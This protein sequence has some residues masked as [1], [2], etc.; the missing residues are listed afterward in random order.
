MNTQNRSK[1]S[2]KMISVAL[3]GIFLWNQI[4]WAAD[5]LDPTANPIND[6]SGLM[7]PNDLTAN[8]ASV[9]SL[10]N[11]RNAIEDFTPS[12]NPVSPH[13]V[14]YDTVKTSSGGNVYY[15]LEGQLKERIYSDGRY[16]IYTRRP[17]GKVEKMAYYKADSSVI[18]TYE[19]SYN[20]NGE[21]TGRI[22]K[23]PDG[24]E[25]HYD[26]DDKLVKK[27]DSNGSYR[28]YTR[29]SDG[30]VETMT[31]C[32]SDGGL[33]YKNITTYDQNGVRTGWSQIN[34]DG[35]ETH[36]DANNE[37]IKKVYA[38]GRY[39][40]YTRQPDGQRKSLTSYYANNK[41][42]YYVQHF[43]DANG[44]RTGCFQEYDGG[45]QFLRD[46]RG[47]IIRIVYSDGRT[48]VYT[49]RSDGKV[50]ILTCYNTEGEIVDIKVYNYDSDDEWLLEA[51]LNGDGKAY[52]YDRTGK[53]IR[54]VGPDASYTENFYDSDG[55]LTGYHEYYAAGAIKVF[56]KDSN[57][58]YWYEASAGQ[59][60][61]ADPASVISVTTSSG[62][63]VRYLDGGIFSVT[64][65]EDG[66]TISRI[67][68]DPEGKLRNAL[69]EYS[70]GSIGVVYNGNLL[71]T[72][73]AGG[74]LARYR[75]GYKVTEYSSVM[76]LTVFYYNKDENG[77]IN[78]VKTIN[79]EAICTY[80]PN[81]I[82]VKFAKPNGEVAE[83]ENGR[84][85]RLATPEGPVYTYAFISE[86]A[87]RSELI[88]SSD[89]DHIPMVI[90]YDE[91]GLVSE[92]RNVK[93]EVLTCES[94][95]PAGLM[96]DGGNVS[97]NYSSND[98]GYIN[99]V[100]VKRGNLQRIYD[101][102]GDLVRI[103]TREDMIVDF[104]KN[105]D[106][107]SIVDTGGVR[108]LYEDKRLSAITDKEG[109][110]YTLDGLN[111]VTRAKHPDGRE[112]DYAYETGA[113]GEVIVVVHDLQS[114]S[115]RYYREDLLYYQVN[116]IGLESYYEYSDGKLAH[117]TQ[118]KGEKV[119]NEFI[120]TYSDTG[121]AIRDLDGAVRVFDPNGM[122]REF[123]DT[124]G[125]VHR[126]YHDDEGNMISEFVELHKDNGTI[127][128][129]ADG[130]VDHV[131]CPNGIV[132]TNIEFDSIGK[133][134]KF[135]LVLTDGATRTCFVDGEWTEIITD[136]NTKLI[137]R[138]YRLVAVNTKGRV[139]RFQPDEW[140]S[141]ITTGE[142]EIEKI[143]FDT[144]CNSNTWKVQTHIS[145]RGFSGAAFDPANDQL[146]IDAG[147]I[148]S[149]Y[150]YRQGEIYLDLQ[151][152]AGNVSGPL[153]LRDQEISFLVKLPEGAFSDGKPLI[154]QVFAK[155]NRWLS[156]YGTEV[157]LTQDGIWYRVSLIPSGK[158]CPWGV[159]D[160][161][162]NADNI[163]LI[164]LRIK[165]PYSNKSYNGKIYMK[166]GNDF[167]LP[168]GETY[169]ETPML[170]SK[171]SVEPYIG[172]IPDVQ[173]DPGNPNYIS[174]EAMRT[175]VDPGDG[176]D[177]G[178]LDLE[179][180]DWRAQDIDY[181]SGIRA[182]T[183]DDAN[184]Q[185]VLETKLK[186]AD[187]NYHH[188]EM[189][190]D[191]RY[192]VPGYN[193]PGPLDLTGKELKFKVKIPSG[194]VTSTGEPC[195]AQ[196]FVK[197]EEYDFQYGTS[198]FLEKEDTW[199]TVTL[200]PKNGYIYNGVTAGNFEPARIINIGVKISCG[201]GSSIDHE[202]P[203]FV[204]CETP[205]EVF[206]ENSP[207]LQI[208]V[209]GLKQY[210]VQ[211]DMI[212]SFEEQLGPEI[213]LA[214]EHLPDYFKDDS[215][216]MRTVYDPRGKIICALKGNSRVEH[217][218]AL[219]RLVEITDPEWDSVVKY[220]YDD[221]GD[222]VD[223]N[224]EGT[225]IKTSENIRNARIEIET[226]TAQAL[227]D[228]GEAK[229]GAI[230]H[231]EDTI[232]SQIGSCD[233]ALGQLYSQLNAVNSWKPLWPWDR[234]KKN[235]VRNDIERQI[236]HVGDTR[237]KLVW[238]KAEAYEQI[239][240]DIAEAKQGIMDE[241]NSSMAIV[242]EREANAEVE[243][244]QQ[245][246]E[247]ILCVYYTKILGRN[248]GRNE[249]DSWL[250]VAGT[251]GCLDPRNRIAFD[252][253]VLRKELLS[254]SEYQGKTAFNNAVRKRVKDFLYNYL[255]P[256]TTGSERESLL[257]SLGLTSGE[258]NGL[259][260]AAWGIKDVDLIIDWMSG[261]DINFGYCAFDTVRNYLK[262]KGIEQ[263]LELVAVSLI[264]IDILAGAI[265]CFTE[266]ALEISLYAMNRYINK[267]LE[268]TETVAYN[269]RLEF[270]DLVDIVQSGEQVIVHMDSDHFVIVTGIDAEGNV[271]YYE[272][273]NGASGESVTVDSMTFRMHWTGY[274]ISERA[275]P[276]GKALS[277]QE[278]LS[279][280]GNLDFLSWIII[281]FAVL[282]ATL[283]FID[284]EICQMIS[285][286]LGVATLVLSVFTV[287]VNLPGII[288]NFYE[289]IAGAGAILR[290][291]IETGISIFKGSMNGLVSNL[292]AFTLNAA[293]NTVTAISYN[294]ALTQG[295]SFLNI[296]SDI[297]RI[298]ASFLT[299]G[300]MTGDFLV[301]GFM[302]TGNFMTGAL[303]TSTRTGISIFGRETGL[304]PFITD[305][306]ATAACSLGISFLNGID[307]TMTG[308]EGALIT[309]H[310]TGLEAVA[311]TLNTAILPHV[312]GELAYSGVQKFAETLGLDPKI[313]YLA[314][315]GIRS[316]LQAG[317][318]T[319]GM[320]GGSP[321]DLW[322]DVQTGLLQGVTSVG[323][324][325]AAQ[326]LNIDPLIAALSS[327]AIAGAIEGFLE[328]GDP[329]R[330]IFDS[331][332]EAGMG[333]LTLGGPGAT[334]WQE[335]AY[336]AQLLDFTNMIKEDGIGKAI[337]VYAAGY[338]HQETINSMWKLG[339]IYDL[340][341]NPDQVE[342]TLNGKGEQVKRIY[343][344]EINSE[345]DK[346]TAN[347]I[348]LSLNDD[349]LMGR[350]EGNVTEHCFY[351]QQS[352]GSYQLEGGEQEHDL[353]NGMKRIDVKDGFKTTKCIYIDSE[354]DQVLVL[355]PSSGNDRIKY[356]YNGKPSEFRIVGGYSD[357]FDIQVKAF[358]QN[359]TNQGSGEIIFFEKETNKIALV[360]KTE[361][362]I[363][364][365]EGNV[366]GVEDFLTVMINSLAS[367]TSP[368]YAL[369]SK[370]GKVYNTFI[371]MY[372]ASRQ[373]KLDDIDDFF[374][375]KSQEFKEYK[376]NATNLTVSLYLEGRI[377]EEE[378]TRQVQGIEHEHDRLI[379]ELT[380]SCNKQRS[381]IHRIY[382]QFNTIPLIGDFNDE[383]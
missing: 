206:H 378:Y 334:P 98:L 366:S 193:Y 305:L 183:R 52:Y 124:R 229:H 92:V 27:V 309:E 36:Y 88:G 207:K 222:L 338:F 243:I 256:G 109:V 326:A 352:D 34:G 149:Q 344:S 220:S 237:S 117:F 61:T 80:D 258:I 4:A 377:T 324:Q 23:H 93:G 214:R 359:G 148:G 43:F 41:V 168:E 86:G 264:L 154:A 156:Q 171:G 120:Y 353:G 161:G 259:N 321:G 186:T 270:E 383:D 316:S 64:L 325:W 261:T 277:A 368:Q 175:Y 135:T 374:R 133:L 123:H 373:S 257:E 8:Q 278:A 56:D 282:S 364:F 147:L 28:I 105:G 138:D 73:L 76:G 179:N 111:R 228:L 302:P 125:H 48:K 363:P 339:G 195:W 268:D 342:I 20:S 119:V 131:D 89:N 341:A 275:P 13:G 280:R 283:S 252:V 59:D 266:G 202:G 144:V 204:K 50:E 333:F 337:E 310:L 130:N 177:I 53:L 166:D 194:L 208:D 289:S 121:T 265:D 301:N 46:A 16:K 351:E 312:S 140:P 65:K 39:K 336:M 348:D 25:Y 49:R 142:I 83:Y 245:E 85:K 332:Y 99:E 196:V 375:V 24:R 42:Q 296:N 75:E 223:I 110:S 319:F 78:Y 82:P 314:G 26:A 298:T 288:I 137:Y 191:L 345:Q 145:S 141:S 54:K 91:Q 60:Q 320:G 70:D 47:K 37:L 357:K 287:V 114:N 97:F 68:L 358:E 188:G 381:D 297:A 286:I 167:K 350:R 347:F 21:S 200:T 113:E 292:P 136:D 209:N 184:D 176:P 14:E 12:N 164:G 267:Q 225:R 95:L 241:Y 299:G 236:Q 362:G 272:P 163:R 155:D 372:N 346:E 349:R 370:I 323:L 269:F 224:Y 248:P 221:N 274:T 295:M 197:D 139:L 343:L 107:T 219:G 300:F 376:N 44:I 227:C 151:Y 143:G 112:Y 271:T 104:D 2:V 250:D 35:S 84:L 6:P 211:N 162:F 246:V 55:K 273:N 239:D 51:K 38:D 201:K 307:V 153:S 9:E 322:K 152:F 116:D 327:N 240:Q 30:R 284:N 11:T 356:D 45:G 380:N 365:F 118:K 146:I 3:A 212:L 313:S 66:S 235:S 216:T 249:I 74:A 315:I 371:N 328:D 160:P 58:I 318:G 317:L 367:E 355:E 360:L 382:P 150:G 294:I 308:P 87:H 159:M 182:L 311:Y 101:T 22:R 185:W 181:I 17:D 79:N 94:G 293:L 122:I 231:V 134:K 213:K 129:Y 15:Y 173:P 199:Y 100:L 71:Q 247:Q 5:L 96:T 33:I 329:V 81:G 234:N 165:T 90:Y 276:A 174:W 281:G 180:G 29:R 279:V 169:V 172:A 67:E 69:I 255:D 251:Q 361:N 187:T 260:K 108:F 230:Q 291:S 190:V 232:G 285:R 126:F 62:D 215:W 102:G 335:A 127:I 63:I 178:T 330:G 1:M 379:V 170:V 205:P 244:L 340:L 218:G 57:L 18:Y 306:T 304:D 10:V 19:Y 217:F 369:F 226:K 106:I 158:N 210:A 354:G 157:T 242:L 303:M 31:Y 198:V 263:E 290:D 192:D 128:Y 32:R 253:G 132:I 262:N 331:S 115:Y 238:A 77:G 233:N 203:V 40:V 103:I 254:S 7:V 72:K 189:F